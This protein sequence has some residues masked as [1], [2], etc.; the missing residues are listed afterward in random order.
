MPVFSTDFSAVSRDVSLMSCD[1]LCVIGYVDILTGVITLKKWCF[2]RTSA[3]HNCWLFSTNSTRSLSSATMKS[4]TSPT[5]YTLDLP[6][7]KLNKRASRELKPPWDWNILKIFY[8][9]DCSRTVI[10]SELMLPDPVELFSCHICS[11]L[12]VGLA[13]ALSQCWT[14]LLAPTSSSSITRWRSHY[15]GIVVSSSFLHK[16]W[17]CVFQRLNVDQGYDVWH[18]QW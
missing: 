13:R 11:W 1:V 12:A 2:T 4:P 16:A 15:V 5:G 3:G 7:P 6:S 18:H 8:S 17:S 14:G 9:H 10:S